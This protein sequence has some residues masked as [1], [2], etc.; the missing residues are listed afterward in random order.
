MV[1]RFRP[2]WVARLRSALATSLALGLLA[3]CS[4]S[5]AGGNGGSAGSA[6]SSPLCPECNPGTYSCQG[7][8]GTFDLRIVVQTKD[9]CTATYGTTGA[10]ILC[11]PLALCLD[12]T[13]SCYKASDGDETHLDLAGG[14]SCT[15]L[16]P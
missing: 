16:P 13:P 8:T 4:G 7:Q 12:G 6:G 3:A 9:G 15:R 10:T 11:Q 2:R 14:P 5:G 1:G